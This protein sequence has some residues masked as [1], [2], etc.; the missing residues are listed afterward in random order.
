MVSQIAVMAGWL[1]LVAGG[2]RRGRL[3][4]KHRDEEGPGSM[5]LASSVIGGRD[6]SKGDE[7]WRTDVLPRL[8]TW[9]HVELELLTD[10]DLGEPCDRYPVGYARSECRGDEVG[11]RRPDVDGWPVRVKVVP[12]GGVRSAPVVA[13]SNGPVWCPNG[14]ADLTRRPLHLGQW[15]QAWWSGWRDRRISG[16]R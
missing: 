5:G 2:R 16:S 3:H 11:G 6:G 9:F 12:L 13:I 10:M 1:A 7:V 14:F 15:G 4:V 8:A